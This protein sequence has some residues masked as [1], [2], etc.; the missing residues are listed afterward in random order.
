MTNWI[1][2]DGIGHPYLC[3]DNTEGVYVIY[4]WMGEYFQSK[5]IV[6]VGRADKLQDRLKKHPVYFA[7]FHNDISATYKMK[8]CKDSAKLERA[9]IK[10]IKPVFNHQHNKSFVRKFYVKKMMEELQKETYNVVV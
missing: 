8:N 5:R 7:L 9:L 4:V 10:K 6:Y 3:A 2:P 1:T